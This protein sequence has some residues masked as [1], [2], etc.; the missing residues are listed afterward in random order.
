MKQHIR[1]ALVGLLVAALAVSLNA[2]DKAKA[3][4]VL[5]STSWTA[6]IARAAGAAEVS[7]IAPADIRHPPEYELKPSDLLKAKDADV[8]VY[9]GY[10]KFAQ[11]LAETASANGRASLRLVTDNR[12]E[13]LVAE[14]A[15]LAVLLGTKPA[16]AAWAD[17]F[18]AYA[19]SVRKR[20]QAAWPK[21]RAAAQTSLKPWMEWM[22][23]EVVGVFGP[24]EPSPAQMLELLKAKPDIVIDNYHN[25]SGAALAESLKAPYA[26]LINFPGK[27][28]TSSL[29]DVYAYAEKELLARRR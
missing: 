4:T 19:E 21:R 26:V 29:E 27:D 8:I 6:A 12:P 16:Q 22:G 17:G 15:K 10:E 13:S 24:G 28:G 18:R 5:A 2:Q 20:V 23:F 14:S 11:R 1:I 9:A 7:T 3:A 25:P